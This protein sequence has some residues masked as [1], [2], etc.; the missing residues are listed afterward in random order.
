MFSGH[1]SVLM[2]LLLYWLSRVGAAAPPRGA[3]LIRRLQL[4]T[5][6]C[7]GAGILAIIGNRAHYTVDVLVAL[8]TVAGIWWS[9]AHFWQRHVTGTARFPGLN[10]NYWAL[11][12]AAPP[13]GAWVAMAKEGS[14][15]WY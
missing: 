7:F 2:V 1:A 3:A 4:L 12:I 13:D 15:H 11:G 9:H 5:I 14:S 10:C 6:L 8:Y